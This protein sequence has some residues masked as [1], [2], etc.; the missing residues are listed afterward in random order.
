MPRIPNFPQYLVEEH[1]NWHHARHY[2]D[3]ANPPVGYGLEFL[4][5]HR[6][7]ITR[8]LTW[9]HRNS[10]DPS[11]VEAWT[12]VPEP[13]RQSPCYNQAA[14]ARILLQPESFATADELGRFVESSDIHAC[15]HQEAAK[16]FG[17]SDIND[18]DTAPHNTVFYNIHGMIDRW[19]R[20][21]E[22]LG[23]F[24]EGGA[25][26]CGRF[27]LEEDEVLYYGIKDGSWWLGKALARAKDSDRLRT[28]GLAW[29]SAG[30]SRGFG[31]VNDGRLFRIWDVDGDGK[32]EVLFRHPRHGYWV[33][34]KVK[35]GRIIWKPIRLQ[36]RNI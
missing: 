12:S 2:V 36:P 19:W 16:L 1:K 35:G 4:Q 15:I 32:L 26:W 30:D 14:E 24:H 8:A 28:G 9:Y 23:R 29:E 22:G 5:Y 10:L 18:F 34:G 11:L 27:D 33:E 7:F 13:I 31:R 25:Y 17:E 6:N 21:W 3:K 20:N